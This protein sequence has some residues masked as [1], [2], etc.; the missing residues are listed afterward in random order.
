MQ[1][2]HRYRQQVQKCFGS[3]DSNICDDLIYH[4][5]CPGNAEEWWHHEY[6]ESHMAA[7]V[8]I[9]QKLKFQILPYTADGQY[10]SPSDEPIFRLFRDALCGHT[11]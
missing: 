8:E 4:T 2:S 10:L 5:I 7:D 11:L 3:A 1:Y 6:A 9:I